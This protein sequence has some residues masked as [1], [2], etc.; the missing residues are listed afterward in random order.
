MKIMR[1]FAH[2]LAACFALQMFSDDAVRL[3]DLHNHTDCITQVTVWIFLYF[4]SNGL[5]IVRLVPS[6][7][8]T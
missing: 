5:G 3:L 1:I 8:D 2:D 7:C 4:C 6:H